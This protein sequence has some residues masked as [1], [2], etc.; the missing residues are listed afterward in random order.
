MFEMILR[1][2]IYCSKVCNV[3]RRNIE[4]LDMIKVVILIKV[5]KVLMMK[6]RV[7]D[8]TLACS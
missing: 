5:L 7:Y 3:S 4:A 2:A 1:V 6:S 8:K